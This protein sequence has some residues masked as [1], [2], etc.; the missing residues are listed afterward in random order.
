MVTHRN[1][2]RN[3]RP[4]NANSSRRRV[5]AFGAGTG[6]FL[7]FGMTALSALP[8][9]QADDLGL[10]ELIVEL[11]GGPGDATAGA[12]D[13][14]SAPGDGLQSA[15]D[16]GANGIDQA[17]AAVAS[18]SPA[19][20][21]LGAPADMWFQQLVY[22]PIH[23]AIEAWI[24]S[25][26]GKEVDGF[27]NQISG[28]YLIGDGAAGT[29]ADPDGGA[30]GLWFGDGGNG[31]DSTQV[32][33]A[34]GAGGDAGWFG[35]GGDGGD[36]GAG[37]NGGDGGDGGSALGIGGNG[38]DGGVGET[39]NGLPALGGAGGNAGML[40]GHGDVGKAGTL[41]GG[42][43]TGSVDGLT[44]TGT[45]FTDSDGKVVTLHGLNEVIIVPPLG[46]PA[47]T[48]FGDD[49]AALLAANGF[50]A[51]RVGVDWSLLEPQ[52]GVFDDAYLASI[53]QTVQTLANHHIVSLLD[54]H[55]QL[56]PA[57]AIDTGG[58][59]SSNLPFPLSLFF[60][61]AQNHALDAFW[62]NAAGPGGVG[63]ENYY[64]QMMEHLANYFNGNPNVLGYEIM[65]EPLPGS[66]FLPTVFG[67]SYFDAQ[68]LTPFYDQ[69]SAAI[70]A[71]DPTTP[72]FYEPNILATAG[73]PIQ[74]GDVDTSNGVLSFHDYCYENLGPLGCLPDVTGIM[75]NAMSY[76]KAHD[77]PAF[78]SEFGSSSN[79]STISAALSPAN[80]NMIGWTEW[81]YGGP[82]QSGVGLDGSSASLVN[83]PSQPLTGDNVNT[84]NLTTLAQPYP[85]VVAGTPN[86][87][88]FDNGV[89]QFSYSTTHADGTGSFAAGSQTTISVPNIEFPKGYEV[90]VTG[91]QV[92]SE[93]NAPVLIIASNSGATTVSVTVSPATSG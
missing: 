13:V 71:V 34:G 41:P 4:P 53:A 8:L 19:A 50:N 37:G 64:A 18:V 47:S 83:D 6:S 43:P 38:G 92:V 44:T 78:M 21:M 82:Q 35:N 63:L 68:Q 11:F 26:F 40:G 27:I 51:V 66:Q 1:N 52:P 33:V 16:V 77:I 86:P 48:G 70:R 55:Q 90:N 59:P 32:G 58:L 24:R 89:F 87:W 75:N 23:T 30:G 74:L 17:S 56:G 9:A 85:Q 5:V 39:G 46:S 73:L 84:A 14:V 31:W 61:P 91:G 49:D 20:D 45:W 67:S 7:A 3:H 93:S 36:G 42:P 81:V 88:T 80:Q 72:I 69:V 54:M 28:Q 2:K 29:A 65:N 62:S 76:A 60:D 79:Q 25:D 57:W 15:L 10:G 22:D 12:G